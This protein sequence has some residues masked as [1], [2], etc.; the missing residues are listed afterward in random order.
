MQVMTWWSKLYDN[1]HPRNND[2]EGENG[3]NNDGKSIFIHDGGDD[4]DTF[5]FY[6][7]YEYDDDKDNNDGNNDDNDIF[8]FSLLSGSLS[9]TTRLNPKRRLIWVSPSSSSSSS[10]GQSRPTAGKA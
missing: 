10:L 6:H 4:N 2:E 9:P 7:R 3:D 8:V 5:V 1:G